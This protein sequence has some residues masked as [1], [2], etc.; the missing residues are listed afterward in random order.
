MTFTTPVLKPAHRACLLL[1]LALSTSTPVL[2]LP[3]L[4]R[5]PNLRPALPDDRSLRQ[6]SFGSDQ[7]VAA[8]ERRYKGRAVGARHL[9]NGLYRVRILQDDGKVKTVTVRPD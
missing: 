5:A 7:A 1:A 6:D 9:G 2:A 8:A 3:G 4:D